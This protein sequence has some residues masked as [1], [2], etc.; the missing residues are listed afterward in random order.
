M[1]ESANLVSLEDTRVLNFENYFTRDFFSLY[2]CFSGSFRS[3]APIYEASSFPLSYMKSI[4]M[5]LHRNFTSILSSYV[6]N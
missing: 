5:V 1:S 6:V 3:S 2:F 4:F